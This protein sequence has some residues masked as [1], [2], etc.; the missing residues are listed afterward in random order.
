MDTNS[1]PKYVLNKSEVERKYTR[2]SGNGGQNRNKVET[3]VVLTHKPTGIIVRCEEHRTR[4]K[5][6][7]TAWQRLEDKLGAIQ[8]KNI[9]AD[10]RNIRFDQIGFGNRNDKNRTYR[11]QDGY[12]LDHL[13][14]KR[15][16]IKEL[17]KGNV[18]M[19]HKS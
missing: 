16:T 14:G 1:Q 17:F 15:I 3:V 8:E 7:E 13:S 9:V 11:I 2:G 18:H 4:G 5:N 12:V 10:Q 6:E 19:L